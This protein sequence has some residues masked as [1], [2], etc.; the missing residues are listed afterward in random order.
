MS[1]LSSDH[2]SRITNVLRERRLPGPGLPAGYAALIDEYELAV[3][4]PETLAAIGLHHRIICQDGWRML[5]PRHQ[6]APSLEGHL[7]FA[8]KHE[9]LDLAVLKRLFLALD[10]QAIESIV[11]AKPTGI[12]A[13]R[14]WFLY[15]WLTG[16]T[17]DVP[18]SLGSVK[19]VPAMEPSKYLPGKGTRSPRQRVVNNLPG[20][21]DF[22]PVVARTPLL[23]QFAALDLAAAAARAVESVPSD[24]L[25]RTAAFLLLEDSKA[26]YFIEGENPPQ[27]RIQ[28][29]GRA[30]GEAGKRPLD[31]EELLRL[32]RT[33]IS[34]TRFIPMGLRLEG[35]FI[36]E[37]DRFTQTPLPVHIGAGPEALDSLINGVIAFEQASGM[38]LDPVIA[39]AVLAF[40][41]VYVHPFVDGNG[42]IHR[43]L[44]HQVI[45]RRGFAPKGV[46]FPISAAILGDMEGYRR[47][48]ERYSR[49][50]MP[51]V[52]WKPTD[53]GNVE[54]LNDTA[55]FYRFF[56]ATPH[57]EFLY[58]CVRRTVE[59]DLPTEAGYLRRQDDA[60]RRIMNRVEMPDQLA[61]QFL[62]F[63]RQNGGSLPRRRREGEFEALEDREVEELEEIVRDAFDGFDQ[64][65]K[66]SLSLSPL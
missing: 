7:T 65:V 8:L 44:F 31:L 12:Y 14:I 63:V 35:G 56:D 19:Y 21:P 30:I 60:I 3:P 64:A 17:L 33:V 1:F 46:T 37:R 48:L 61:S 55:D 54:V 59:Q 2:F 38:Y 28:R 58:K 39:A 22:C 34:D 9:R 57:A 40:G 20:T 49:R 26:S 27:S 53:R 4:L 51:V 25:S 32:Q 16:K 66:D 13:R 15:E 5:T 47:V 23:D 24:L 62:L 45:A 18:I 10:T 50:L 29:W 52:Q 42:R 6:P 36:G 43:Y 11:S 41:F